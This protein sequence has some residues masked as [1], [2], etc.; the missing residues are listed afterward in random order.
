MHLF[1]RSELAVHHE[2]KTPAHNNMETIS[3]TLRRLCICVIT[4]LAQP[5]NHT[6]NVQACRGLLAKLG[7]PIHI[8]AGF[9]GAARASRER[10]HLST[11]GC[12]ALH[13]GLPSSGVPRCYTRI[14]RHR[15]LSQLHTV[16]MRVFRLLFS[17]CVE[18]AKHTGCIHM[19]AARIAG[20]IGY[21]VARRAP[22]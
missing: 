19:V 7:M 22:E 6:L 17:A 5:T 18:V 3:D 13:P 14:S 11:D 20:A 4:S 10:N 8:S 1:Y 21:I 9:G 16:N 12:S 2:D 15:G